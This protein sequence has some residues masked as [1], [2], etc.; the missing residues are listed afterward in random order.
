MPPPE[1]SPCRMSEHT[2]RLLAGAGPLLPGKKELPIECQ[3]RPHSGMTQL[4]VTCV[5][6][7]PWWGGVL[8]LFVEIC[9]RLP[10]FSLLQFQEGKSLLRGICRRFYHGIRGTESFCP[11]WMKKFSHYHAPNTSHLPFLLVCFWIFFILPW[12]SPSGIINQKLESG[13]HR[14]YR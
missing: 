1:C 9:A 5:L 7:S 12:F 3:G 2:A 10:A 8:V 4:F 13:I 14:C 11:H 6:V